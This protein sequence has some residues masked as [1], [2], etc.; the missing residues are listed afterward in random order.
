MSDMTVKELKD[1]VRD[2]PE[3]DPETGEPFEVWI[4]TGF[5]V[6]SP[7]DHVGRLNRG[8]VLFES[9]AFR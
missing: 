4:E 2:L 9:R 8:D 5:G 6:S 3:T 7:A 1:Y